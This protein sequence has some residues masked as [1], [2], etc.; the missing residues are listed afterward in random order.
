[1]KTFIYKSREDLIEGVRS[2]KKTQ[3]KKWTFLPIDSPGKRL[4]GIKDFEGDHYW[5]L[6]YHLTEKNK[7]STGIEKVRLAT[8]L[9]TRPRKK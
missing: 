7:L 8:L 4:V 2:Y 1:M 9:S 6:P 3:K 5:A